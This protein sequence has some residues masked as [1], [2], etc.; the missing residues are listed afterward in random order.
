MSIQVSIN[1]NVINNSRDRI[2]TINGVEFPWRKEMRG[3]S[4]TIID[5]RVY[6]DGFELKSGKWKR[7]IKALWYKW[8]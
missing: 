2:T 1:N 6:I 8:F 7:T 5:S 3:N 4:C